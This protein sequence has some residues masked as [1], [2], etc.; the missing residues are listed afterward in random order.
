[1]QV[2]KS[3]KTC[4]RHTYIDPKEFLREILAFAGEVYLPFLAANSAALDAGNKGQS[5]YVWGLQ[6]FC[7]QQE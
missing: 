1:M 2:Q 4:I 7:L 5:I 3:K 6:R